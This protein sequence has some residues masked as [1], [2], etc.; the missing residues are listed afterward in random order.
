MSS[1]ALF[2]GLHH[3]QLPYLLWLKKKG[4]RIHGIDQNPN[5][6]GVE[7]VDSFSCLSYTDTTTLA[8]LY[9]SGRFNEVTAIFTAASQFA[10]IGAAKIASLIRIPYLS[11]RTVELI[12][13]KNLFYKEFS[14]HGISIPPTISVSNKFELTEFLN[15][16]DPAQRFFVKSDQSKNPRY[17]Y[18][19]SSSDLL[20]KEINWKKDQFLKNYVVHPEIVGKN[21]RVNLY[22]HGYE[23]YDFNSGCREAELDFD[24]RAV[25]ESALGE[26]K[27]FESTHYL[28]QFITKYDIIISNEK[29]YVLDIG[30]DPPSRMKKY[31]DNSGKDFIDFYVKQTLKSREF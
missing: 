14:A 27:E 16:S 20:K 2:F 12:L 19:G 8:Q 17:I 9:D 6:P 5:A 24:D 21:I 3:D 30:I 15:K 26:L 28:N 1:T 11:E 29:Y 31:W 25:F 4:W 18:C 22:K 13:N 7:L 23:I 10:H